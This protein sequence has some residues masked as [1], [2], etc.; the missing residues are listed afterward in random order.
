M[1]AQQGGGGEGRFHTVASKA[2]STPGRLNARASVSLRCIYN[3]SRLP[4]HPC[5][6]PPLVAHLHITPCGTSCLELPRRFCRT[7]RRAGASFPRCAV[8]VALL[9]LALITPPGYYQHAILYS[10]PTV[11]GSPQIMKTCTAAHFVVIANLRGSSII[12]AETLCF[13]HGRRAE[14]SPEVS[15][16]DSDVLSL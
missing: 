12:R 14:R 16:E 6:T 1:L 3:Y 9:S 13:G 11:E 7:E 2:N 4:S 8:R 10:H 15:G 5:P